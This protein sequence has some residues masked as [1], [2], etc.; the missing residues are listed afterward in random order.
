MNKKVIAMAVTAALAAPLAA[1]AADLKVSGRVAGD[2][3][4]QTTP[5]ATVENA[6]GFADYGQSRIQFDATD[7]SGWYARYA[8]DVR[9]GRLQTEI[10]NIA[11]ALDG[12]PGAKGPT[13][14]TDR[15]QYVGVKASFGDIRFGRV[16]NVVANLEKD[17]LIGTFLEYRNAAVLGGSWGSASFNNSMVQFRKDLGGIKLAVE[18]G[19]ESKD[20]NATPIGGNNQGAYG[21]ALNGKAGNIGYYLGM[22]NQGNVAGSEATFTKLGGSMAMGNLDLKLNYDNVA[23]KVGT[24]TNNILVGLGMKMGSGKIDV[25]FATKGGTNWTDTGSKS[26]MRLAYY[27]KVSD[28]VSWHAGYVANGSGAKNNADTT[29]MGAGVIVKF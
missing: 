28:S 26:Y 24:A 16:T 4:S 18:Y 23:P 8:Q 20:A 25:S 19:P 15:D 7:E 3:V 13:F 1:Q 29:A 10:V 2:F 5:G 22:N 6:M 12:T 14:A 27:A 9:L 11:G 21:V 17:P